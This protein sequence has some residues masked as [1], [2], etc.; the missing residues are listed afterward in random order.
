MSEQEQNTANAE[1]VAMPETLEINGVTY[2]RASGRVD[3]TVAE[4]AGYKEIAAR[5]GIS[6][7]YAYLLHNQ[8]IG[9]EIYPLNS[10]S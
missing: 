8:R 5:T 9:R 6:F 4:I 10:A 1:M 7:E 2:L 3:A